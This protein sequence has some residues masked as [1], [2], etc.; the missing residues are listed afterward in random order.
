MNPQL[1]QLI[2]TAAANEGLR[3]NDNLYDA[4]DAYINRHFRY[5]SERE[6][7]VIQT[8]LAR[9]A[10]RIALTEGRTVVEAEDA[11]AA[12]WLFHLPEQPDDPCAAAGNRVLREEAS[13]HRFQRGML[14]ESFANFLDRF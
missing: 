3:P 13:R 12:V 11:K 6:K 5:N 14:T 8:Y 9:A 7:D 4:L 2:A 1:R 10:I